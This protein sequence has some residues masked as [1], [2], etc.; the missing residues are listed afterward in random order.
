MEHKQDKIKEFYFG[1]LINSFPKAAKPSLEEP[2]LKHLF[3]VS[4]I[5]DAASGI[6]SQPTVLDVGGGAGVN[7]AILQQ[8]FGFKCS[9]ID[10]LVEFSP[11]HR[12]VMGDKNSVVSR[13]NDFGVSMFEH[14]FVK[15]GFPFEP[16]SFDVVTCFDVI[17]HFNFSPKDVISS[18]AK[19]LKPGG[20][21][22]LGTPN[23]AHL[24]NRFK[25]LCGKNV[26]EDFDYYYSAENF[27]G[28]IREFL[29]FEL[30]SL[31]KREPQLIYNRILYSNYP[32]KNRINKIQGFAGGIAAMV[33][34]AIID[35]VVFIAP[36]LNYYMIASARR[37]IKEQK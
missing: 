18:M 26:W 6:A 32:V 9:V 22:L 28:H 16:G 24:Y 33:M 27:F 4:A 14:N 37:S 13:L 8:V 36:K 17:E 34:K 10:R 20:V 19:L 23:Q 11:E 35:V 30:I 31:V 29:P 3:E 15:D 5:I 2:Y 1:P 25:L 7:A 12:R 21:L